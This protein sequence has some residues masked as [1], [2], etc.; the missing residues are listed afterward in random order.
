MLYFVLDC[1]QLTYLF[2]ITF[3]FTGNL[4]IKMTRLSHPYAITVD[5]TYVYWTDWNSKSIHRASKKTFTGGKIIKSDLNN[6][7]DIHFYNASRQQGI[8]E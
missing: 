1:Q 3:F 6:V 7:R 5:N 4:K 8:S 2:L